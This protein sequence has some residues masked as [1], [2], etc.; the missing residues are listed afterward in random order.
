MRCSVR[1]T[2]RYPVSRSTTSHFRPHSSL[3]LIPV[4]TANL[5]MDRNWLSFAMS[6]NALKV[7]GSHVSMLLAFARGGLADLAGLRGNTF[8]S[9]ANTR[10]LF[11][12]RWQ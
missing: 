4:N 12:T 3:R 8:D 10:A 6:A 2:R 7:S 11:K 9:T 1:V 5:Y